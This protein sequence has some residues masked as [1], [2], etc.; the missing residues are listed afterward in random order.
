[1]K[2]SIITPTL[3]SIKYLSECYKSVFEMQEYKNIEWIIIDGGSRDGTIE[4]LKNLNNP[5]I[6]IYSENSN[7]P[8]KAYHYGI[9]KVS[10]DIIGTL[11]SDDYYEN[12]IFSKI[13]KVF[14]N[15]KINWLIG[16]N[17]I[18]NNQGQEIRK[19]ITK[20]KNYNL[21]N[22]SLKRLLNNN[23][24]PMQSVFWKKNF[25]PDEIGNFNTTD[26]I[27][28]MDYDMWIRMAINSEPTI[29]NKKLSYFRM[30]KNSITAK[31][32]FDQMNQMLLI[33]CK[34]GKFNILKKSFL[35]IKII[36][37]YLI[38]KFLNLFN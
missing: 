37:I 36:I 1:M 10:G 3:N 21:S 31:G 12:N 17:V 2:I 15:P 30:H 24:I 27:E 18:I 20:Y 28:S 25:M 23:F 11:G 33:S 14:E 22:Y 4:F 6:K 8:S 16:S 9:T 5:A 7:H 34:Y 32:N 35:K 38:Y 29:I 13:V 19:I 26:F